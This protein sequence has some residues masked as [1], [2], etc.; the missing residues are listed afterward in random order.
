MSLPL[1]NTLEEARQEVLVRIGMAESAA[2]NASIHGRVD[3]AI[4]RAH[5]LYF[6]KVQWQQ[7]RSRE[8]ITLTTDVN[9]YDF[10]D[11]MSIGKISCIY[12]EQDN[13]RP[14]HLGEGTT[15]Q[16]RY[17]LSR[18]SGRPRYFEFLDKNIAIYPAPTDEWTN[19][20]VDFQRREPELYNA[21]ERL[22]VDSELVVAQAT[23]YMKLSLGMP[24]VGEEQS[25]VSD[26]FNAVRALQVSDRN[27]TTTTPSRRNYGSRWNRRSSPGNYLSNASTND[28]YVD[29][30]GYARF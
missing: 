21:S 8:D 4:R 22:V 5:K 3:S 1:E 19:L 14:S 17:S 18:S 27:Y 9:E 10:P 28:G 25:I 29:Q 11:S 20:V 26:Y 2:H 15:S 7:N 30:E 13:G 6:A 16:I 12:V 24:G 23:V